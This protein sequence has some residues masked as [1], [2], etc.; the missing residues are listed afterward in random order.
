MID[1]KKCYFKILSQTQFNT[2]LGEGG[3]EPSD[4]TLRSASPSFGKTTP[5]RSSPD[6]QREVKNTVD[7]DNKTTAK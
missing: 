7:I 1:I 4:G 2:S 6:V 3:L 5:D